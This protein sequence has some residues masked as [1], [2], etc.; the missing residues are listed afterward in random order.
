[1]M[2]SHRAPVAVIVAVF[3]ASRIAAYAA[4]IHLDP[5]PL[6]WY[7][8]YIEPALLKERLLE[9][10]FYQHSQPPLF[11]LF[12][13]L[14]LKA[15]PVSYGMALQVAFIAMGML[16]TIGLYVLLTQLGLP[17]VARTVITALACVSPA[18][19]LYENWLFY[20]Y[21]TLT[22]LIFASVALHRFLDRNSV[23][24]GTAFFSLAAALIYLRSVFQFV[25]LL[26]I[27][28]ALL[29]IKPRRVV[30]TCSA[31]PLALVALLYAK[32]FAVF[33][34]T[35]TSSWLG[36]NIAR[37]TISQ[38]EPYDRAEL[39]SAG[40]L[41]KVSLVRPFSEAAAYSNAVEPPARRGI[42]V[43]DRPMKESGAENFNATV[44]LEVSRDYRADALWVMR[45]RPDAYRAAV[46]Q[47]VALFFS[48]STDL[49]FVAANRQKIEPYDRI[50]GDYVYGYTPH[51]RKIGIG[52]IAAYLFALGYSVVM[53]ANFVSQR[54]AP[55]AGES[56]I[57]FL[58]FTCAYVAVVTSLTDLG[59]N[60]RMRFILDWPI[61]VTVTSAVYQLFNLP[62]VHRRSVRDIRDL[63][64]IS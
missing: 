46:D 34:T 55:R 6:T 19:L 56:T 13:G 43:L 39:V 14:I 17:R 37:V 58:V 41:H 50:V 18:M 42:A 40:S 38:L 26:A 4:G 52:V 31:I 47:A 16:S 53:V 49:D 7:W 12:L 9:S 5:D 8:Q 54:R 35:T 63:G 61:A 24:A 23:A 29:A 62:L 3:A 22:V 48:S 30:L 44:Y 10:L 11:N 28:V 57:L 64:G 25:W 27:V 21:P 45:N 2:R 59:E 20:E 33:G 1:M 15:F 60:Q 36:M 32:N 51:W